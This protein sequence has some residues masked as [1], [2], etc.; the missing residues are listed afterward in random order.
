MSPF[1]SISGI[2][3]AMSN[4]PT[5][6]PVGH[7]AKFLWIFSLIPVI[8]GAVGLAVPSETPP[9]AWGQAL[10]F[11]AAVAIVGVGV[12]VHRRSKTAAQVGVA[13]FAL[14]GIALIGG[15]VSNAVVKGSGSSLRA[16][17]IVALLVVWP[18]IKLRDALSA[19][20]A[21]AKKTDT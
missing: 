5:V 14:V 2:M 13:L 3:P 16:L 12:G 6:D 9:P 7:A 1:T 4:D 19:M 11:V 20:K 17:L 15:A 18:I 21:E 8:F 10:P